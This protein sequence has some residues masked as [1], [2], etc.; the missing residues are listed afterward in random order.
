MTDDQDSSGPSLSKNIPP[1]KIINWIGNFW[2]NLSQY[3]S[4]LIVEGGAGQ[5][6]LQKMYPLLSPL[7]PVTEAGQTNEQGQGRRC[8][9]EIG[10]IF[11]H[12]TT[13]VYSDTTLGRCLQ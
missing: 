3:L 4:L 1:L 2:S 10:Q 13:G 5:G 9:T 8:Q 11:R 7:A 6:W 12:R